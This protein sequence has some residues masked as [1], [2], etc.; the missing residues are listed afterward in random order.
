M[1]GENDG[2]SADPDECGLFIGDLANSPLVRRHKFR[3]QFFLSLAVT[4]EQ[5]EHLFQP[6]GAILSVDIKVCT[7]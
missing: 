3:I 4:E 6:Y 5:L 1:S 2:P 7:R